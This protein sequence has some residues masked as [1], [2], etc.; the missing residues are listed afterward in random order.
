MDGEVGGGEGGEMGQEM[1]SLLEMGYEDSVLG[2][3]TLLVPSSSASQM[4][5][6]IRILLAPAG[7]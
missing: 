2:C 7:F 4:L 3:C 6:R 1:A 5:A